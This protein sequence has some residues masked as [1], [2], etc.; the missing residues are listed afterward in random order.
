M[1]T[2]QIERVLMEYKE[3]NKSTMEDIRDTNRKFNEKVREML[4]FL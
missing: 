4:F 3:K 1:S 2:R